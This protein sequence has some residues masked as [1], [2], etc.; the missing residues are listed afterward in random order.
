MIS[1]ASH[2]T[3]TEICHKVI[4]KVRR[5]FYMW[6]GSFLPLWDYLVI[7]CASNF[8]GHAWE[9]YLRFRE[10]ECFRHWKFVWVIEDYPYIPDA[11]RTDPNM[12][13]YAMSGVRTNAEYWKY[14]SRAK[15]LL[16]E[17]RYFYVEPSS[18]RQISIYLNHGFPIKNVIGAMCIS[19]S[20]RYTCSPTKAFSNI[21]SE[22]NSVP[23]SKLIYIGSPRTDAFYRESD[24][25]LKLNIDKSRYDKIIIWMP[26][27]RRLKDGS[28][29]RTDG[30]TASGTGIALLETTKDFATLE[31][32]CEKNNIMLLIKLHPRQHPDEILVEGKG[33]VRIVGETEMQRNHVKVYSLLKETDALISDYSSVSLDY[34]LLNKPVAYTIN[35]LNDYSRGFSTKDPSLFMVGDKLATLDQ[36]LSFVQKVSDGADDYAEQRQSLCNRFWDYQDGK[37]TERLIEFINKQLNKQVAKI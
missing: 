9:I 32:L 2:M 25:L 16:C 21:M 36:L 26:T 11:I 34:L 33:H 29:E 30:R 12:L 22:Q 3:F 15:V 17:N 18:N 20:I 35:D 37:S 14:I 4:F 13:V 19:E 24:E 1:N 5:N 7:E 6:T 8:D 31:K 10:M 23:Q 27:F 28:F